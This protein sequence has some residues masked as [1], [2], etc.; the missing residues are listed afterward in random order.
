MVSGGIVLGAVQKAAEDFV[1]RSSR[2]SQF[3]NVIDM[4]TQFYRPTLSSPKKT[5]VELKISNIT[6]V[7][8]TLHLEVKQKGVCITGYAT[9]ASPPLLLFEAKALEV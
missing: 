7:G 9:Y 3:T 8:V 4:S 2:T 1:S 5:T 6:K